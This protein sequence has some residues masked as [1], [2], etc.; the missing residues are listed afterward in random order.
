MGAWNIKEVIMLMKEAEAIKKDCPFTLQ[1][2][3]AS[4]C[5]AWEF[6]TVWPEGKKGLCKLMENASLLSKP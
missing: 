2:C 4:S 6:D 1:F 5:M 3:T